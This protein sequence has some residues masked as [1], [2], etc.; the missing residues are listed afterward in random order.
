MDLFDIYFAVIANITYVSQNF[1]TEN[2]LGQGYHIKKKKKKKHQ[3]LAERDNINKVVKIYASK[4][5]EEKRKYN[6]KTIS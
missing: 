6:K 3:I 2:A 1:I 5:G 4:I